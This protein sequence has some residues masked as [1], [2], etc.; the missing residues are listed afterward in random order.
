MQVGQL[1]SVLAY[2]HGGWYSGSMVAIQA[3]SVETYPVMAAIHDASPARVRIER[4]RAEQWQAVCTLIPEAIPAKDPFVNDP[5]GVT[6]KEEYAQEGRNRR[7]VVEMVNLNPSK[8]DASSQDPTVIFRMILPD[9]IRQSMGDREQ[10]ET[11]LSAIGVDLTQLDAILSDWIRPNAEEKE[12]PW[13]RREDIIPSRS[14]AVGSA[15]A[16][17]TLSKEP[18]LQRRKE[19][20]IDIPVKDTVFRVFVHRIELTPTDDAILS[21]TANVSD[22]VTLWKINITEPI[23]NKYGGVNYKRIRRGIPDKRGKEKK[24]DPIECGAQ[25]WET[26]K[27]ELLD[28]AVSQSSKLLDHKD[29]ILE[30]IEQGMHKIDPN[31]HKKSPI[32]SP[33]HVS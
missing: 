7:V 31:G 6:L 2:L 16:E 15:N 20:E 32:H 8:V 30:A 12:I 14:I 24:V 23:P 22:A 10:F 17:K 33:E 4:K 25:A 26:L 19:R 18:R 11:E 13:L 28:V 3:A 9:V 1:S 27:D 29:Q 5:I 21:G